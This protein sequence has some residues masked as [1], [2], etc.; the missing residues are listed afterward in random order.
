[1]ATFHAEK[2]PNKIYVVT[3]SVN[4]TNLPLPES[5]F[6]NIMQSAFVVPFFDKGNEEEAFKFMDKVIEAM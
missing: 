6:E 5:L 1:M 3:H 2:D 4:L